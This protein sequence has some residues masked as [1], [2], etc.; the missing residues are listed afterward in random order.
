MSARDAGIGEGAEVICRRSDIRGVVHQID[1]EKTGDYVVVYM[2]NGKVNRL[3]A[4]T[5]WRYYYEPYLR[6]T[7]RKERETKK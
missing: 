3:K 1:H 4:K 7:E 5:F 6:E 2:D